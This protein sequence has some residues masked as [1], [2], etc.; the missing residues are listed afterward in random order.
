MLRA[1]DARRRGARV[2]FSILLL[3]AAGTSLGLVTACSERSD[4]QISPDDLQR[5]ADER[6]WLQAVRTGSLAAFTEYLQNFPAGAH[7]AEARDRIALLEA[8]AG[9][10]ADETAW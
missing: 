3:L 9:R 8:Q 4:Q 6:T 2:V 7:A 1:F 10:D 5:E